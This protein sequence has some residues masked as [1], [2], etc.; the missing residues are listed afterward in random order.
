ME[1]KTDQLSHFFGPT[2]NNPCARRPIDLWTELE[3]LTFGGLHLNWPEPN[4]FSAWPA[5]RQALGLRKLH[6]KLTS[7]S[8]YGGPGQ[9]IDFKFTRLYEVLKE[10]C[11]LELDGVLLTLPTMCLNMPVDSR[12]RVVVRTSFMYAG[13]YSLYV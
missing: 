2:P 1:L 7:L 5:D 9:G 8:E 13:L 11:I 6:V 3:S 4:Q 12:L 10:N